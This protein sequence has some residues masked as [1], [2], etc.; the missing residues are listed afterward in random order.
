M[1]L[2]ELN[3]LNDKCIESIGIV[4]Q[5]LTDLKKCDVGYLGKPLSEKEKQ[6]YNPLSHYN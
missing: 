4:K 2:K 1:N 6:L 5:V 3:S